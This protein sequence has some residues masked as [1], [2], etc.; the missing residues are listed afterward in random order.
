M[1]GLVWLLLLVPLIAG[2]VKQHVRTVFGR[3]DDGAAHVLRLAEA[4][5]RQRIV[6]AG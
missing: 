4:A 3:Y 5:A 6:A 1:T 2:A